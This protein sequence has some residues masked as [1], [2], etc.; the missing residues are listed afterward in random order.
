M[1]TKTTP[2][3]AKTVQFFLLNEQPALSTDSSPGS[4]H[5]RV[6]HQLQKR[7]EGKQNQN[8]KFWEDLT[9]SLQCL[10][11]IIQPIKAPRN[12]A[13]PAAQA[14]SN[15]SDKWTMQNTCSHGGIIEGLKEK[16]NYLLH[17]FINHLYPMPSLQYPMSVHTYTPSIPV[18]N[19]L[20][21]RKR[22]HRA[23]VTH[24]AANKNARGNIH[25]GV[26]RSK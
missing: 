10:A 20:G 4:L 9:P 13:K 7:M 21:N 26:V 2:S 12:S 22:K 3:W 15:V 25:E 24:A 18:P 11:L 23:L 16:E 19:K 14:R 5:E 6:I 8:A 1:W 17:A